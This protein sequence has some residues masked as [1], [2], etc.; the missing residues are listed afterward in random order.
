MSNFITSS[1]FIQELRCT[2]KF[3]ILWK[4]FFR[5]WDVFFVVDVYSIWQC[6][7]FLVHL[8]TSYQMSNEHF[9]KKS[10][11]CHDIVRNNCCYCYYRFMYFPRILNWDSNFFLGHYIYMYLHSTNVISS[12]RKSN[13]YRFPK[14][15]EVATIPIFNKSISMY[16][17]S[18]YQKLNSWW[19]IYLYDL[20]FLPFW[21]KLRSVFHGG[22]I[23]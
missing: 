6:K 23:L 20:H 1:V 13:L 11:L 12:S 3:N 8:F 18:N 15:T 7:F 14:N 22:Q 10:I 21:R 19:R 9:R 16:N 4:L 17:H 2:L 5:Y